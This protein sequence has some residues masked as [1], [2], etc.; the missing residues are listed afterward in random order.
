MLLLNHTMVRFRRNRLCKVYH[1]KADL[2]HPTGLSQVLQK[3]QPSWKWLRHVIAW[4]SIFSDTKDVHGLVSVLRQSSYN[5][6]IE[7]LYFNLVIWISKCCSCSK[8]NTI[9]ACVAHNCS[10]E[11]TL[12]FYCLHC[13]LRKSQSVLLCV[14]ITM[15]LAVFLLHIEMPL[16]WCGRPFLKASSRVR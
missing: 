10:V 13:A 6:S 15:G 14:F 12:A 11:M 7:F 16:D 4:N 5:F 1:P 2:H 9:S 3:G 8:I